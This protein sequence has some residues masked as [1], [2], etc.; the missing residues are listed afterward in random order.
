MSE[1]GGPKWGESTIEHGA[2][3]NYLRRAKVKAE[4]SVVGSQYR[5]F[6]LM[7]HPLLTPMNWPIGFSP[8]NSMVL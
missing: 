5:E 8:M 7:Q 1:Q 6:I 2:R 4:A 3:I